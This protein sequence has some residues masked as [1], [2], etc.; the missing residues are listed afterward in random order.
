ME[1]SLFCVHRRT[2]QHMN[3]IRPLLCQMN[4]IQI[5]SM[6]SDDDAIEKQVRKK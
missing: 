3:P 1:F 4:F 5:S 2:E 6:K